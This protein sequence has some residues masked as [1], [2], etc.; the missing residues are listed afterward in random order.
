M[1]EGVWM[2]TALPRLAAQVYLEQAS[3]GDDHNQTSWTLLGSI[4][5]YK[6]KE[7]TKD[8]FLTF[9]PKEEDEY[10]SAGGTVRLVVAL[11]EHEQLCDD[12]AVVTGVHIH[13]LG[14]IGKAQ[15]WIA[16]V[17]LLGTLGM[18]ASEVVHRTL[19]A[20]LG[21]FMVLTLLLLVDRV[22]DIG[23]VVE[24]VDEGALALLFGMMIMIGKLSTTGFFEV[25]TFTM[26]EM[27]GGSKFRLITILC[28]TTAVLSAFLDNVT[29]VMLVAPV[30]MQLCDVLA[31]DPLPF[32]IS[33]TL[34]SNIGG[35][36]TMIGD[37]PNIIVGNGLESEGIGFLDFM[38]NLAPGVII[39]S[40]V[41]IGLIPYLF[42]RHKVMG[43]IEGYDSVLE[44]KKDYRI[45]NWP[46][47]IRTGVV[48]G[49]VILGFL[50]H[51][52][53]HVNPA[54]IALLGAVGLIMITSPHELHHDFE[55]VEW[56]TLIFFAALFVMVEGLAEVGLIR[57]I[58]DILVSIIA[59]VEETQRLT[60]TIMLLTWVSAI[61]S[62]FLDNI[63]YTATMVPVIKQL[64]DEDL[65][66]ELHP[67]AWS[68]C[69]GACLGG[70]GSLVGASANVVVAGIAEKYG[71]HISF[72]DF[73]KAGFPM[74]IVSV[75]VASAYL[76]LVWTVIL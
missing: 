35:T 48:L 12:T 68:L 2:V 20:M 39:I 22:P 51:P 38:I 21:S 9:Y 34:Y 14:V 45:T 32:L 46:L 23:T 49:V 72:I 15:T 65:G 30:T 31:M 75:T 50:L 53:H 27:C 8:Y 5:S 57:A 7:E 43:A 58:G 25:I 3:P 33:L 1:S 18:I 42:P 56:D 63:P 54:W 60:V 24:W 37:P 67:L 76:L 19:A 47:L 41:C 16:L 70:N 66:L 64:V 71:H 4:G 73:L 29:T 26:I 44:L 40:F 11:G 74:M 36:A 59:S 17:I 28:A 6:M 69:F 61:V 13:Q 62:A 55:A 52:L 10:R